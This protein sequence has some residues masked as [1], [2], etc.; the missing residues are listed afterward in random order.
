MADD[1]KKPIKLNDEQLMLDA[2]QVAD[3]Y[4]Q[5]T[6]DLF[7]QVI[8]RIKE[9]GSASLD[10]NP[11]IWQLE[12][13]NEMG[14]LNEDNLKLISDR[15]GIA[16]E[17]LRYVI[18][19]EGYQI[20]KNTKEQLLEATGGDFVA[21]SL[22]QTNL[23]AYV[24]QT[25]G[26]INN[27]IN[28]TLPKS[29]REVYQSIIEEA[30]AKVVTGLATSDK[31]IS[32]T[33]MKWAQKGFY[34]FTD[35]QGKRWKADTYARQVIK[36]TAWR[37][38]R[39][40][41]M[42]PAEELGI[43]TY[44][45]SK[46]A[47]AREMCAPLQHQI[48]TTGVARTEKGERILALSDYGYGSAGGC[49]GINCYH[50]I[51][52]FVVGANYKPD[53]PDNLKDL[54]PEQAIEN[55]NVQAKQRAL[56]R[57]IRQSKEFLHVAEKLGDQELIDKY[58]SKVRIQQG[59][60]RDYLRQ[61][62]FLH[63]DYAREKYYDDP[64]TKA[65]K[66]I[67]VRKELEK[68]EKHRAEQKEMREKF[69]SAVKSG[70]IKTEINNEHFENHVR[71]TKGYDKYL[72]KN[73]E[74]GAPPPSYLTI[75]KEECQAL[76][77]RYAGTGQFKYNPK[78]NKMQEIISQNKPI[79]TYIDP[80]TGEVIENATDFRI[81]YSKTGSHIVPTIKGKGGRK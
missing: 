47:T 7:D 21:N 51:T 49:L 77:D 78:S 40:V 4:H 61:H 81:H 43:D 69:N 34:G 28:T 66:E 9:R 56:E 37:V 5:L 1:K 73:L 35:S 53:L 10:D 54:T 15:S 76:V 46:K 13:M 48:V 80:R 52:P 67:K 72:Q 20:Y 60:M 50:E 33:V 18:Q 65:K 23:A 26:D 62:P 22:I 45:Y 3:I 74:K 71:G 14:L 68:L 70:I 17:Q 11:Y 39:E 19:N 6:L 25:M 58:K 75:T 64:Y 2:S 16:E 41:R 63:R 12:K 24:N 32:D 79:G 8:D 59:A 55:A 57:S 30:T 44:Y 27:L 42:A 38:Y 36:S 29:V 31:A